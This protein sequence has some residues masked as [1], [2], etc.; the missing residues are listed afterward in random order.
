MQCSVTI[1]IGIWSKRLP[2]RY[3]DLWRSMAIALLLC[4]YTGGGRTRGERNRRDRRAAAEDHLDDTKELVDIDEV[5]RH[6]PRSNQAGMISVTYAE[7]HSIGNSVMTTTLREATAI[8]HDDT[9][10]SDARVLGPERFDELVECGLV[11]H[12]RAEPGP[13]GRQRC[14][15]RRQIDRDPV[16]RG[17]VGEHGPRL[18]WPRRRRWCRTRA[19]M[20]ARRHARP[21][22]G[23]RCRWRT[24]ARSGAGT[25]PRPLRLRPG[26]PARR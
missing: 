16:G 6:L 18:R 13:R 8:A 3:G 4:S 23:V 15:D 9:R 25:R 11:H 20:W 21:G 10:E 14:A 7:S 2:R 1:G 5:A 26:R 22:P 17:E 12:V 24:R 19:A